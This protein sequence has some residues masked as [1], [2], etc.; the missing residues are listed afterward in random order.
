ME[1]GG[2]SIRCSEPRPGSAVSGGF[3]PRARLK[4]FGHAGAGLRAVLATQPNAWIHSAATL[5][6]CGLGLLLDLPLRDW[7]WLVVAIAAVWTAEAFNTALEA[8]ADATS[9]ERHPL[10][11]RAKD[12]AAG[13][14]LVA[15]L[16][17]ALIGLAVLGPPLLAALGWG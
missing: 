10:V 4:S 11:A 9:P 8:L 5:A 6:V 16:G 1:S 7:L 13:A 2:A 14:V 12:A 15:A 3:S 17:A